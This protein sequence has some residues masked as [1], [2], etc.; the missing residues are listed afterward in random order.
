MA[1]LA[2]IL[3]DII[4]R[5]MQGIFRASMSEL[6]LLMINI[7]RTVLCVSDDKVLPIALVLAQHVLLSY[8]HK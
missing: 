4:T 1:G 7:E 2:H 5:S 3:D 8:L 6:Y